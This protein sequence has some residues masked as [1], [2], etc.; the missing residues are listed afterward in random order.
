MTIRHFI[1]AAVAATALLGSATQG[2]DEPN[3]GHVPRTI[4]EKPVVLREGVGNAREAVTTSSPEAQAFYNQG[5]N[6]LHSY[7][8]IEAA[9]S[10]HQALRLDANL[11]MAWVGLSRAYSGVDDPKAA[12]DALDK[13]KTL[14]D[15]AAPW[16]RTRIDLRQLQLTAMAAPK[17]A[18]AF[19]TYK[20]AIDKA[21]GARMDDVELWLIRGNAEEPSPAGRGQRGGAGS[22]AF[23]K[24]AL[25]LDPGHSA[26]HHFLVHSYEVIGQI[27]PALASGEVYAT[28]A[29]SVPHAWHMWGHD[30]RRGAQIEKAI[31]VFSKADQLER[32]YYAGEGIESQYDWHHGHNLDLLAGSYQYMGRI[33]KAEELY[34]TIFDLKVTPASREG[35]KATSVDFFLNRQMWDKAA[36]SA[37]A[38]A[39]SDLPTLKP[40]SQILLGQAALGR[41]D[42]AG[43]A[44]AAKRAEQLLAPLGRDTPE[45]IG[46]KRSLDLFLATLQ[47]EGGAS[48]AAREAHV[49]SI[50]AMRA[51]LGPDA[52]IQALF[53]LEHIAQ[54]ARR[55]GDWELARIATENMLDHDPTYGGSHYALALLAEHQGDRAKMRNALEQ[56]RTLWGKAD[57]DFP[58]LKDIERRLAQLS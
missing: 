15:K 11:A 37:A 32:D 14:A 39:K 1:L 20:N 54:V 4:L 16:E 10:F 38:L 53:N 18:E 28:A 19:Q 50:A 9:R 40:I 48:D 25:T 57:P 17:N 42:K 21:L 31:E 33:A 7:V 47:L 49:K 23:Y 6:Y 12:Q 30:L 29:F 36:T 58:E 44:E 5:I 52:W 34:Q 27:G 45:Y 8:W 56:A 2:H 41:G 3:V 35:V 51:A 46:V 13:A 26:A 24:Q 43:A 22:I 55:A